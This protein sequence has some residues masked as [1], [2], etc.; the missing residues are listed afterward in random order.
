MEFCEARKQDE[1][2][3]FPVN[4][5]K[6]TYSYLVHQGGNFRAFYYLRGGSGAKGK[7]SLSVK[8]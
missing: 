7:R 8:L 3:N 6:Y 1:F 2:K 4:T 5:I